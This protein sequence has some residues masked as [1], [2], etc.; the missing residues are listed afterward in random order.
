MSIQA[1]EQLKKERTGKFGALSL[2]IISFIPPITMHDKFKYRRGF[3][4]LPAI[5]NAFYMV[6]CGLHVVEDSFRFVR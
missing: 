3:R 2:E 4:G 1:I 5:D 6:R